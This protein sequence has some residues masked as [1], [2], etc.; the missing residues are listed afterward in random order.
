[1]QR[2]SFKQSRNT[3]TSSEAL[4]RNDFKIVPCC[5]DG[6]ERERENSLATFSFTR[7]STVIRYTLVI[8]IC[9]ANINTE[10]SACTHICAFRLILTMT[11]TLLSI[12]IQLVI[13]MKAN[14]RYQ[15][16]CGLRRRSTAARLL[17]SR[18]WNLQ[19]ALMFFCFVCVVLSGRG[20]CGELITHPEESCPNLSL[21]GTKLCFKHT[22]GEI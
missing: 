21:W 11:I 13:L 15:W 10:K 16:P 17:R 9:S 22:A 8:T 2:L 14:G 3:V 19:R 12:T 6:R 20:F 5:W 18:V 4:G 1:L 7:M